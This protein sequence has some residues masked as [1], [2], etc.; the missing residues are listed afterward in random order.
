MKHF[1]PAW[2][3]IKLVGFYDYGKGR[4]HDTLPEGLEKDVHL[5]SVGVGLRWQWK[6][7]LLASIDLGHTL[8]EGSD[9]NDNHNHAHANLIVQY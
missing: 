4:N 6:T 8:K 3:N 5:A 1:T 2:N 9:T 7:N